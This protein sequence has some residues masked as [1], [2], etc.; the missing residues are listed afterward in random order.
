MFKNYN[1]YKKNRK[2][3][4]ITLLPDKDINIKKC[5]IAIIIPH[6]DRIEHLIKFKSHMETMNKFLGDNT[7]DIY[8]IDQNNADKFNRGFLLNLGYLIA[9]KNKSYDRYIFH[10][11]DSYPDEELF[12]LYFKFLDYN[13]HFASPYLGY[14]YTNYTF[15]GGI[16]GFC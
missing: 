13:I 10:D 2:N 12:K 16:T 6:R 3:M 4:D 7:M 5:S 8:I 14:K 1:E 9:K 15:F 11:V